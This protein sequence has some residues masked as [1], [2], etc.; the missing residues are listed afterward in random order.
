[1]FL[2]TD[3]DHTSHDG[4]SALR[5][6]A[7][8]GHRDVV[9]LLL[10]R[11]ADLSYRDADGRSTLYLLALENNIAMARFL[12][13]SNADVGAT[14]LEGRTPLHVTAWQGHA[15]MVALLLAHGATVDAEDCEKR[16]P[17]QSAA[18]QGH[19]QIVRL[20]LEAGAVVDHTCSQGA[21]ALSIA[22]QEGH[23]DCVVELLKHGANPSHSDRCGRT[24]IK[25]ALKGGHH[26][27]A[28]LLEDHVDQCGGS[29]H[30]A[31]SAINYIMGAGPISEPNNKQPCSALLCP[32]LTASPADSPESTFEKRRST[33]SLGQSS[34]SSNLTSSTRSSC[35]G[36]HRSSSQKAKALPA[37]SAPAAV[38]SIMS[39]LLSFTQQIQQCG[40][41]RRHVVAQQQS[42]AAA[43]P[44]TPMDDP[45][46]PIYASPP[47][48]PLSDNGGQMMMMGAGN[49]PAYKG[50]YDSTGIGGYP[51]GSSHVNPVVALMEEEY[52]LPYHQQQSSA[53]RPLPSSTAAPLHPPTSQVRDIDNL[54]FEI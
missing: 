37:P 4:R 47:I 17:L 48:S 16:T 10:C 8:E 20:L 28:K 21:T 39:P 49:Y 3:I 50:R 23:E 41:G 42:Q 54:L 44:L 12:L 26:K 5:V 53:R 34:K 9:H 46:S 40:R 24:A 6:A 51:G 18:W 35:G 43:A 38:S 29:L 52:C 7:L 15:H 14:D 27:L 30:S 25:V 45:A 36:G 32:G 19:S 1:M 2:G 11:G 22:A 13:E 33:A 31:T